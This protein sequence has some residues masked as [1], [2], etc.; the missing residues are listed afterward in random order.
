M[1]ALGMGCK[2]RLSLAERID[3]LLAGSFQKLNSEGQVTM[4]SLFHSYTFIY[5]SYI[6]I[7]ISFIYNEIK[8][9]INV[10]S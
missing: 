4:V 3:Q 5:I 1:L 10:M 9:S 6:H 2:S 8:C 7:Y